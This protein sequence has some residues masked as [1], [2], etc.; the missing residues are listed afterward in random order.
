[1]E[2]KHF[3]CLKGDELKAFKSKSGNSGF[4]PNRN[5][6]YLWTE[7]GAL[8]H[9]KSLNTDKAEK[10]EN[11]AILNLTNANIEKICIREIHDLYKSDGI[12]EKSKYIKINYRNH[13]QIKLHQICLWCM[14]AFS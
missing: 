7:K 13:L 11:F 6:L 4:A 8:L 2:G 14:F 3:Y 12:K 1:M 10:L 5:K 9:A